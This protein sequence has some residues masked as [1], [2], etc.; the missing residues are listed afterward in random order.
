M[1][2]QPLI[3]SFAVATALAL[4]GCSGV[5][6]DTGLTVEGTDYSVAELQQAASQFASASAEPADSRRVIADLAL[7]PIFDEVFAGSPAAATDSRVRSA[8][9]DSGI[10][11]PGPATLDARRS[12]YYQQL[13]N[14]PSIL[15]DPSMADVL[16]KATAI[17]QEDIDAL[18]IEVNPRYGT[19]DASR[20]GLLQEQPAWIR[21]GPVE[22]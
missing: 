11:D 14:D 19:W 3:V 7:L 2:R 22:N 12:R 20:G 16:A 21:S 9:S 8:L 5:G 17:T 10:S 6:S 15:Q 4:T 1:K 18:Q 13:L